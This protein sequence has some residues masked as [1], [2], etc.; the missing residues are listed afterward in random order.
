MCG[1]VQFPILSM[2]PALL[3]A[4]PVSALWVHFVG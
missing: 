3:L 4:M 1:I 2:L